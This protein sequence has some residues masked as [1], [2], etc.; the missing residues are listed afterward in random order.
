MLKTFVWQDWATLL[1]GLVLAGWG[2]LQW[3]GRFRAWADPKRKEVNGYYMGPDA[4]ANLT[5][6]S[7]VSLL[8]LAILLAT[9]PGMLPVD[10]DWTPLTTPLLYLLMAGAVACGAFYAYLLH[11]QPEWPN[12]AWYKADR[13]GTRAQEHVGDS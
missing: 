12:P 10:Q 13:A 5:V 6:G 3:A 1:A 8:G 7:G 2:A 4:A 9:T 11:W